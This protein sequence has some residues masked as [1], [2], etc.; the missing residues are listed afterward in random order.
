[1]KVISNQYFMTRQLDC[2]G[3]STVADEIGGFPHCAAQLVWISL[4]TVSLIT[5]YFRATLYRAPL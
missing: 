1:M 5:D 3:A 4:I 2:D